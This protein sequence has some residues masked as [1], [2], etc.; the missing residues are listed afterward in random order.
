MQWEVLFHSL[1]EIRRQ[2]PAQPFIHSEILGRMI[3]IW[4]GTPASLAPPNRRSYSDFGEDVQAA[5]LGRHPIFRALFLDADN[6]GLAAD[7]ALFTGR[8]LRRND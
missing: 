1:A 6:R 7:P 2:K 5:D 3:L 8:K 4:D